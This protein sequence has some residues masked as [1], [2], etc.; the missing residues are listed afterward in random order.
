MKTE[1][2]YTLQE[3]Y[4][5]IL[6]VKNESGLLDIQRKH[7][8]RAYEQGYQDGIEAAKNEIN[9]RLDL[10]YSIGSDAKIYAQ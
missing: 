3:A 1:A 8:T 6:K 10:L 5:E 9:K 2:K 4:A 7:A